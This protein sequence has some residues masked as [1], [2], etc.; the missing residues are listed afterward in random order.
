MLKGLER[1]Y[2]LEQIEAQHEDKIRPRLNYNAIETLRNPLYV[3]LGQQVQDAS[4]EQHAARLTHMQTHQTINNIANNN[5]VNAQE[6]E[7]LLHFHPEVLL[8]NESK[9]LVESPKLRHLMALN[10]HGRYLMESQNVPLSIW[11]LVLERANEKPSVI[12]E[13]LKGPA[14]AARV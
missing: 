10:S 3:K 5:G 2:T 13:F 14:L 11:S 1:R 12:Y 4:K 9:R 6:L 7:Q 8:V